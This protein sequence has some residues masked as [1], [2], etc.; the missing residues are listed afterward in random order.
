MEKRSEDLRLHPALSSKHRGIPLSRPA[1]IT[2]ARLGF[3]SGGV[4]AARRKLRR[5][6]ILS[7]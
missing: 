4:L 3:R 7:L 5:I 6:Y 2:L 1:L